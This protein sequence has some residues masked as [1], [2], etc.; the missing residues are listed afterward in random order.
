MGSRGLSLDPGRL[1]EARADLAAVSVDP[2]CRELTDRAA[3]PTDGLRRRGVGRVKAG[4]GIFAVAVMGILV[5]G[6]PG[7]ALGLLFAGGLVATG[8]R[9][10]LRSRRPSARRLVLVTRACSRP[11]AFWGRRWSVDA[12]AAD[13]TLHRLTVPRHLRD[14]AIPGAIG[15][16]NVHA[17]WLSAF[18]VVA[19]AESVPRLA[20]ASWLRLPSGNPAAIA[21]AGVLGIPFLI[22]VAVLNWPNERSPGFRDWAVFCGVAFTAVAAIWLY[23]VALRDL[24]HLACEPPNPRDAA[25]PEARE[26]L[27]SGLLDRARLRLRRLVAASGA[28]ADATLAEALRRGDGRVAALVVAG[29]RDESVNRRELLV[30]SLEDATGRCAPVRVANDARQ[31]CHSMRAG[32]VGWARIEG[33]RLVAFDRR[34]G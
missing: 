4:A 32:V 33:G 20:R 24:L 9:D 7:V 26:R 22:Y 18:E 29:P 19:P 13:G 11:W 16:A 34:E 6:P 2:A 17:G 12:Q 8:A 28:G 1:A 15:V 31:A 30:V 21:L 10:L 27:I 3:L 25:G 5:Y 23:L 14:E